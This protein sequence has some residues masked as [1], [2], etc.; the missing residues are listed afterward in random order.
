LHEAAEA[1]G[2]RVAAAELRVEHIAAMRRG[3]ALP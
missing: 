2:F 1:L 3:E